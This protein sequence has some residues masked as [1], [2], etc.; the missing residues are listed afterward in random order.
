MKTRSATELST[1][2]LIV[3]L[4][5]S[6]VF[7]LSLFTAPPAISASPPCGSTITTD[8]TLDSDMTCSGT[9]ITIGAANIIL[10]GA[11]YTITGDRTGSGIVNPSYPNVT[12]KNCNITNCDTGIFFGHGADNGTI[13][14]NTLT[15]NSPGIF[16][17]ANSNNTLTSNTANSNAGYISAGIYISGGSYHTLD[18]NTTNSNGSVGISLGGSN[19]TLINNTANS[20]NGGYSGGGIE[21]SGDYN[22]LTN[23][24]ANSNGTIYAG[25]GFGIGGNNNVLT[26][27]TASL[28]VLGI[29]LGGSNNTLA[30]NNF[31]S[32]HGLGIWLFSASTS[33]ITGNTVNSNTNN[34]YAGYDGAG[35]FVYFDSSSN[36][37]GGPG[38]GNTIAFNGG[39]GVEIVSADYGATGN[40][41][42]QNS[43]FSNSRLGIDLNDDGVTPDDPCD[44][45]MSTTYPFVTA[46]NLQNFPVLYSV[47]NSGGST[48]I[49]GALNSTANTNFTIEFFSNEVGNPSGYGK[50]QTFIGSTQVTTGAD[51]S[52]SFTAVFPVT[53]SRS[54]VVT[55]TAT[56]PSGNTSEFSNWTP[57]PPPY[58][59]QVQQPINPNGSSVFSANRG[60]V[61]V[62]FTLTLNGVATCD[63]PPAT[64]AVTRT[65][66]GTI[67]A[68]DES[69]YSGPAD[70]G[71]NFRIDSCQ[72]VYNLSASALGVGTYRVDININGQV[73]GSGIFQLK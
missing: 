19:S 20:N 49:A 14:N 61:P 8:T 53:L 58:S 50:G 30:S 28:N 7:A 10:D 9:A 13:T 45:D 47:S 11:G 24:T 63:L 1:T 43:I 29:H 42:S 41:I 23:N 26:G 57:S 52:G 6:L 38:A 40:T 5:A 16:L 32:N 3:P 21:I 15:L 39:N 62:K 33:I 27:N 60:V 72:Y 68:I 64:I 4:V 36:T 34:P 69:L 59:A 44:T 31:S 67:G 66:G 17:Q 48:T 25:E 55:M 65:A 35:I 70:T 18:S 2:P 46:N 71:S 37:I 51:C 56:D 12:V 73:V 22:I 54:E